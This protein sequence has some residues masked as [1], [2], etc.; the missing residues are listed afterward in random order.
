MV[1]YIFNSGTNKTV[2]CNGKESLINWFASYNYSDFGAKKFS[3]RA[4]DNL[5]MNPNDKRPADSYYEGM[6]LVHVEAGKREIMVIDEDNRVID[7]RVFSYQILHKAQRSW[8]RKHWSK[9]LKLGYK[10]YDARSPWEAYVFRN[11]PVPNVHKWRGGHHCD[12]RVQT[13]QERRQAANPEYEA[14]VRAARNLRNLPNT[15]DDIPRTNW[16]KSWK[17]KKMSKQWMK[18]LP[19]H[20]NTTSIE[21]GTS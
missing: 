15:F 17:Q 9:H 10:Y 11:G 4:F 2:V 7:P 12:R 1:Y 6:N 13:T 20:F 3:N 21:F 18:N 8:Y 14:Y 19:K 16:T 5:A